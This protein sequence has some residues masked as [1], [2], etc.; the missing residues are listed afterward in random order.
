[1]CSFLSAIA[2]AISSP[3]LT[4]GPYIHAIVDDHILPGYHLLASGAADLA[5]TAAVDCAPESPDLISAY[6]TAFDAWTRVS[7]LRF[8]PSERKDRS[9]A[10]A[11]WPDPRGSTPKTLSALVGTQD[12]AMAEPNALAE[13]SIAARGFYALEFL[14]FDPQFAP[15]TSPDYHCTLVKALTTDIARNAAAITDERRDG[16]GNLMSGADDDTYQ[17]ANEAAQQLFTSL[18]IGQE[19]TANAR[20]G[21]PLG[22]FDTPRPNR[23]DIR[24]LGRSLRHIILLLTATES[25]PP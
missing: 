7:H 3:A 14:L 9:F 11:F 24:R 6:H 22:T 17:T 10:L 8:G 23:A 20:M 1:M 15:V 18:T 13:A 5:T 16:Y 2:I 12:A 21:R 25:W 19:F 4:D